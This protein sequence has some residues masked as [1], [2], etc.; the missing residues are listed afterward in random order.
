M[1]EPPVRQTLGTGTPRTYAAVLA[2]LWIDLELTL[3]RLDMLAADGERLLEER[4]TLPALQ[5]ELHCAAELASVL[6]P[7]PNAALVHEELA[8]ALAEARELTA[9]VGEA[10]AHGGLEAA[11]PLVWEWRGVL[12]RVRFARI[13]LERPQA[14]PA[15]ALDAVSPSVERPPVLAAAAVAIG[16]VLVLVAALLGLW[17]LVALTLTG[18]MAGSLLL[19][20]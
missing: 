11:A 13:R 6:T 5:Y 19:R 18:T 9:E 7:P 12:F 16:S 20:P 3:A 8:E 15:A 14:A 4:E 17:L 10:L 2:G 1:I